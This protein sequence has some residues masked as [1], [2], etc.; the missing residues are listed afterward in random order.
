MV[1]VLFPGQGSQRVGMGRFYY[2]HFPQARRLFEEASDELS[3]DFKKLCFE[4]P[5]EVLMETKNTQPAILLVSTVAWSCLSKEVDLSFIQLSA[6]HSVGEYSALVASG[7]LS[8]RS[9]LQAVRQRGLYMSAIKGGGM[10]ALLGPSPEEAK[11]FCSWV[12]QKSKKGPIEPANFNSPEQTV[13]SGS[14]TALLWAR[15]HLREYS[16][17]SKKVRLVPLRVS[18]PFHSSL[19]SPAKKELAHFLKNV[20]FKKPDKMVIQNNTARPETEPTK[21]RDNLI[22]QTQAPVLWLDSMHL[23]FHQG[24]SMF[25]ELGEGKVL[26]GLMNKTDKTKIVFHFNSME[27]IK[28]IQSGF[29][30][31]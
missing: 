13:L 3:L 1:A 24:C 29:S 21:I 11:A 15:N 9:A 12:E 17:S 28:K 20:P 26:A 31:R 19:M 6:G 25:L 2:E 14:A 18:A 4:G 10:S 7:V 8:F 30:I 22:E 16:F 23:L 27:D 5:E